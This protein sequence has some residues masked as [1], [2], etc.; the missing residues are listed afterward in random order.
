[1][2]AG[3]GRSAVVHEPNPFAGYVLGAGIG[4][5]R[6]RAAV[7]EHASPPFGQST[8]DVQCGQSKQ[9]AAAESA[10]IATSLGAAREL[11][12]EVTL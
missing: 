12:F 11:G 6:I 1:V 4:R 7:G 2:S 10:A 3:P 8:S 9:A 5:E